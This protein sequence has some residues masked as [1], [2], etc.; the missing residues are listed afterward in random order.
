MLNE[1]SREEVKWWAQYVLV[2][3]LG[4]LLAAIGTEWVRHKLN[5]KDKK[6]DGNE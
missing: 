3:I 1:S 5:G 2:P 6:D 4:P